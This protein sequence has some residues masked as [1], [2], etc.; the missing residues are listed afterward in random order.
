MQLFFLGDWGGLDSPKTAACFPDEEN[1][2]FRER[3]ELDRGFY[4]N[5]RARVMLAGC[6]AWLS[7]V[8]ANLG[9]LGSFFSF[10]ALKKRR[11]NSKTNGK[12]PSGVPRVRQDRL[13]QDR[14]PLR[15]TI[16]TKQVILHLPSH[17]KP[18]RKVWSAV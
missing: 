15:E 12:G 1:C 13:P 7:N 3:G 2:Q 5:D 9:T 16:T 18:P 14:F 11:W 8:H 4:A 17:Q 6:V 10:G